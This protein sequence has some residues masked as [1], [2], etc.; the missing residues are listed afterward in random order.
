MG[1]SSAYLTNQPK[2]QPREAQICISEI[3]RTRDKGK[4]R[5]HKKQG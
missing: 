2:L 1:K 3:T 4:L 5:K